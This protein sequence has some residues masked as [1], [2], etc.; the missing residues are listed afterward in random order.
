MTGKN[1]KI[2]TIIKDITIKESTFNYII[3]KYKSE[4]NINEKRKIGF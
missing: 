2:P 3:D 4:R 1:N